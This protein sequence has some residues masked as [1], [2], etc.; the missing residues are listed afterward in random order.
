MSYPKEVTRKEPRNF[1]QQLSIANGEVAVFP[2]TK[3]SVNF[4]VK[5]TLVVEGDVTICKTL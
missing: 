5:A 3:H 4:K 2:A 1:Y